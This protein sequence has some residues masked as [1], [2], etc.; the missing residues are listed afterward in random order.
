MLY[1]ECYVEVVNLHLCLGSHKN[2]DDDDEWGGGGESSA[3]GWGDSE[4]FGRS[5]GG[6]G[7]GR[8]G[9]GRGGGRGGFDRD[10]D[11]GDFGGGRSGRGGRG[12]RGGSRGGFRNS[13]DDADFGRRGGGRGDFN[14]NSREGEENG[15]PEKPKEHYIPPEI[16]NVEDLFATSI[17]IGENFLKL[18]DV[19]VNVSAIYF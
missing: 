3:V 7:G 1:L 17:N 2:G 19:E 11:R 8:G 10:G 13:D 5:R 9:R 15:E 18:D 6:R 14:G 12:G 4:D 16:E